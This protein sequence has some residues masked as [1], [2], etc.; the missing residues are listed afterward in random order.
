MTE[1][2]SAFFRGA[3]YMSLAGLTGGALFL[4]NSGWS[5]DAR[6]SEWRARWIRV[7]PLALA[8]SL[9]SAVAVL[10]LQVATTVGISPTDV[11]VERKSVELFLSGTQYG[12]LGLV[13]CATAIFMLPACVAA[14]R[15]RTSVGQRRSLLVVAGLATGVCVIGPLSGHAAGDEQTRWMTPFHMLHVVA[16]SAWLGGLPLWISLVRCVG[17]SPEDM[18]CEYTADALERFSGLAI[19]CMGAIIGSG[20]VLTYGFVE[21]M[22]DLL[23]TS[24]G[25]LVCGKVVLLAGVMGIASQARLRFLPFLRE[26]AGARGLYPLAGR[27][28]AVELLL[29]LMILVC[30]GFLSQSAP[31]AHDQPSWWLPFRVSVEATWPIAPT[32]LV[33]SVAALALLGSTLMLVLRWGQMGREARALTTAA[34]L[35]SASVVIWQLSVPAYPDT[36]RRSV[37]AY[38]TVSIVQG[39]RHFEQHC[40][41]CHGVGGLGNGPLAS[42][43]PRPSANLSEPHTALHTAGDM[44][45]WLTQGFPESGMPGFQRELDEQARWD[46]INFMRAFSQGFEA[47]LLTTSVEYG[48][49]WLGAPNFYFEEKD[50]TPRELKDFRG[51]G[52]VLLVFM[53]GDPDKDTSERLQ[54]LAEWGDKNRTERLD[55]LVISETASVDVGRAL[56]HVRNGAGEIMEAYDLLSRTVSNRG[57]GQTLDMGRRHMEFLIDR[58]GYIRGRWVPEEDPEGWSDVQRL[59]DEVVRLATEPRIRPP[60]DDHVH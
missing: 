55:V 60:P 34:G 27:W 7:L 47:R 45:W 17:S 29:S 14:A 28:V 22:G 56:V 44:F 37:S 3:G 1:V 38:L 53:S 20:V 16:L 18:R 42:M 5:Q 19:A 2:V 54:K 10:L 24:Y 36:Y 50:G 15:A 8:I 51:L 32:P 41:A 12:R 59:K 48:R 52:N 9:L 35:A 43:L 21:T 26:R 13:K 30:A 39:K 25:L 40:T 49:P 57:N 58:F 33:V 23:G 4:L 46:V 6:I 31:A 11:F